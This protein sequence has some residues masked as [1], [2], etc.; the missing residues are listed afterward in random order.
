MES[1]LGSV[2]ASITDGEL[3]GG[4]A[5]A[6]YLKFGISSLCTATLVGKKTVLTAAHCVTDSTTYT[7]YAEE[8]AYVVESVVLHPAWDA[9]TVA[10]DIALL[11]LKEAPPVTPSLISRQAPA[12]GLAVTIVGYGTTEETLK[13]AGTKRQAKNT[14]EDVFATRFSM[15]GT[16]GGEGN[17]CYGDSGGPGFATLGGKEVQ[18]GI[19]SEGAKPCG[20]LGYDTRVDAYTDW[21][22][23]TSGGDL[24]DGVPPD[25]ESPQVTITSPADKS[26][27]PASIT[28]TADVTDNV[29]VTAVE[30]WVDETSRGTRAAAPY[31]F[32]LTLAAGE[33]AVRVA[34]RDKVGNEGTSQISVTTD[35]G[36]TP[37]VTEAV[38]GVLQGG[39]GLCP[40]TRG[41]PA[42][43]PLGLL[44]A[45]VLSRRRRF[46]RRR[47]DRDHQAGG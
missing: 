43:S 29:G 30:V 36:G 13:D 14:I 33:H 28:V 8:V 31:Q 37:P 44:L 1:A 25:T 45:L 34:A 17:T 21:L 42:G 26:K 47:I 20:T 11:R 2:R 24:Y 6:G 41:G 35:L 15:A 18:I 3:C 27:V 5:S 10:N 22:V 40:Q 12:V 23:S 9:Q 39:C 32:P 7:F 19:T 4:F 38:G 46:A 16:G